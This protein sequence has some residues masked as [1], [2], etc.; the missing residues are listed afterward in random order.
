MNQIRPTSSNE[1]DIKNRKK[2]MIAMSGGVD[3]SVAAYL[4]CDKG[5]DCIGVTMKLY[6]GDD[7]APKSQKTCCSLR[8]VEDARS[9]AF[10]LGMPFYVFNFTNEFEEQV[11]QR[12]VHAYE[13]GLTPN[14]C[15]DCNRYLKFDKLIER[16]LTMGYDYVVTGH[17][18]KIEFNPE[19][20]RFLLKKAKDASKDQS[21]VLYNATQQQLSHLLLPLGNFQKSEI[22]EIASAQ[23]FTNAQKQDSQDICFIPSGDYASFIEDFTHTDYPSGSF[24]DT[25]GNVLG[26]HKGLIRYTIGQR[27]GLALSFPSPLYVQSKDTKSNTVVLGDNKSLFSTSFIVSDSNYISCDYLQD[28]VRLKV[29][30]RYRQTE[31]WAKITPLDATTLQID[32]EEPQR[33]ISP[34]QAAVFYDE[35]IVVGGGR[36]QRLL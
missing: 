19:S 4:C 23:G 1:V 10:G 35:D 28:T 16:A 29:K 32:F 9:V 30:I 31:Q 3:S 8:D 11:I 17:Y 5:Y 36:I 20:K 22:R 21:Y 15:I 12:F 33:A 27:K 6:S 2:A 14:P 13:N 7:T 24:V 18:A 26:T 34:G 25:S